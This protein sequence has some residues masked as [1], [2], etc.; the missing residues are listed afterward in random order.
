[1]AGGFKEAEEGLIILEDEDPDV[2]ERFNG[3]LYTG[4]LLKEV[5]TSATISWSELLDMCIFAEKRDVPRLHNATIDA[6]IRTIGAKRTVPGTEIGYAWNNTADSS[7]LH[8]F[9]VDLYVKKADVQKCLRRE[10]SKSEA[11]PYDFIAEIAI[12]LYKSREGGA[13]HIDMWKDRC[14]WHI[15]ETA[16]PPCEGPM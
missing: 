10:G 13:V 16:D 9:L 1:M 2:F 3:W 14:R 12:G 8:D 6:M 11:I 4:D 15:H 7:K 5:E